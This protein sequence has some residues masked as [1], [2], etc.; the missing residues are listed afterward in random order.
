MTLFTENR[1][2]RYEYETLETYD[3]GLVLTGQEVKAI[4]EGG[5]NL[6][7]SYISIENGEVWMKKADIRPYSK[8]SSLEGIDRQRQRKLLLQK[9]EIV[10]LF[11]KLE[12]KGLTLI[13]ISLYPL[14]RQIKL[15]FALCRGKH[16]H[17][18][19]EALKQRDIKREILSR[20]E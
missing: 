10:R 4:R 11:G 12:Q 15:R 2:A 6:T 5:A 13:P 7:G 3:A 8:V 19:R 16:A 18:K 9:K 1:K 17:D 20:D 14:G